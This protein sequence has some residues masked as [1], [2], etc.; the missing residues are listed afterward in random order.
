MDG[1]E[2]GAGTPTL[3]QVP[4]VT[5]RDRCD[6]EAVGRRWA[7][8]RNN[9]VYL[10][11]CDGQNWKFPVTAN[12]EG[13][14]TET[15]PLF[16]DRTLRY[17]G[18]GANAGA[19]IGGIGSV[20][21]GSATDACSAADFGAMHWRPAD[22]QDKVYYCTGSAWV[23]LTL[24]KDVPDLAPHF[25]GATVADR[26]YAV[27][28]A[29]E[30]LVLPAAEGGDGKLSYALSTLPAGLIF[31]AATRTLSGTPSAT[32]TSTLTY[33]ATDADTNGA[34]SDTLTTLPKSLRRWYR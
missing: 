1:W 8:S 6:G 11:Y 14:C 9:N 12:A 17:C 34:D 15:V 24:L 22:R 31:T 30:D 19:E 25:S 23:A 20:G 21:Y 7:V 3:T 13:R 4:L 29:I 10:L 27:G 28:T 18:S 26:R 32:G 16:R 33:T 2:F 5:A